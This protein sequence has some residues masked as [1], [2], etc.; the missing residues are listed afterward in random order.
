MSLPRLMQA[1]NDPS[2]Q[3]IVKLIVE[4]PA[5]AGSVLQQDNN[6][7]Y[8]ISPARVDDFRDP[9]RSD[10]T[11]RRAGRATHRAHG[12]CPISRF[13]RSKNTCNNARRRT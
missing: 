8:R 6:A 12:R 10:A 9:H 3:T 11:P 7:Y 4:D 1:L 5:L 13:E 2:R